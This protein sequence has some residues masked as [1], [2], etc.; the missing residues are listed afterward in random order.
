MKQLPFIKMHW[1]WNDFI[2]LNQSDLEKNSVK[3]TENIVKKMCHRNFWI[4]SDGIVIIDKWEKTEFKYIMY[5]PDWTKAEM[6]GNG[7]R[8]YMK[9]LLDNNLTTKTNIDVET[10]AGIL[11]LD[12]END[13]VTVDM[14]TP[15]IIQELTLW[16]KKLWDNFKYKI[17]VA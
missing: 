11:N 7:I 9:Y 6:C 13:I 14:W 17:I 16:Q 5:N 12:I 8:C 3:L 4:G 10:W 15:K 2:L 1:I